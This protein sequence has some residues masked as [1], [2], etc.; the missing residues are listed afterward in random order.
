MQ[1]RNLSGPPLRGVFLLC[2]AG[3]ERPQTQVP[4]VVKVIGVIFQNRTGGHIH[5]LDG[6]GMVW[7][8]DR[9]FFEGGK[10]PACHPLDGNRPQMQDVEGLDQRK[11]NT[12]WINQ[13]EKM[14]G[15]KSLQV[16]KVWEDI[17]W[18]LHLPIAKSQDC[19]G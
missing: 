1:G 17:H 10:D 15:F 8:Y 5:R 2:F 7:E 12:W 9:A 11:V 13:E 6:V 3:P 18:I 16:G 19:E 14:M 4:E